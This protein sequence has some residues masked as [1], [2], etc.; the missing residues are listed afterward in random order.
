MRYASPS[1]R[2]S[3]SRNAGSEPAASAAAPVAPPP[4]PPPPPPAAP[5][6]PGGQQRPFSR[7]GG[8]PR[9]LG[10]GSGRAPAA[11][12]PAPARDVGPAGETVAAVLR[13]RRVTAGARH[14]VPGHCG[15]APNGGGGAARPRRRARVE[16]AGSAGAARAGGAGNPAQGVRPVSM[17]IAY[18]V[19]VPAKSITAA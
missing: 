13:D 18:G 9:G 17:Q 11:P 7:V 5:A 2:S 4:P 6:P 16:P 1:A 12:A 3:R 14:G 19:D 10:G 15:R 8:W